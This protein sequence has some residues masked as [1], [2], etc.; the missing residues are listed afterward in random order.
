MS[1]G[2]AADA[3]EFEEECQLA[4]LPA[5]DIHWFVS[6]KIWFIAI[7]GAT[8]DVREVEKQRLNAFLVEEAQNRYTEVTGELA[9]DTRRA[10]RQDQTHKEQNIRI[11]IG[12]RGSRKTNMLTLRWHSWRMRTSLTNCMPVGLAQQQTCSWKTGRNRCAV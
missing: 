11:R 12:G 9:G 1:A 6:G 3:F 10:E 2:C 8:S 4:L 7:L 5:T